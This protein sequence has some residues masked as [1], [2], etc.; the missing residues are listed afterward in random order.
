[1]E[2]LGCMEEAVGDITIIHAR[3][4]SCPR[5]LGYFYCDSCLNCHLDMQSLVD[6][7]IEVV[8]CGHTFGDRTCGETH[9][10][11]EWCTECEV[12]GRSKPH[13]HIGEWEQVGRIRGI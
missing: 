1:M 13:L 9:L 4:R 2:N 11:V 5:D 10:G 12:S 7:S 6:V 3:K 8:G